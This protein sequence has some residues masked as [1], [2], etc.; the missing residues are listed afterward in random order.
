MKT[1]MVMHG[2]GFLGLLAFG[3][4]VIHVGA[5]AWWFFGAVMIFYLSRYEFREGK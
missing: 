1:Y 5:S 2:L 4:Y 3:A